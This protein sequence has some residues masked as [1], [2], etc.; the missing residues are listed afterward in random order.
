MLNLV[1]FRVQ[2]CHEIKNPQTF[3]P[4][5]SRHFEVFG[6]EIRYEFHVP[7]EDFMKIASPENYQLYG[8]IVL[9]RNT[10]ALI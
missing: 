3:Q 7:F 2:F 8:S 1:I 9:T 5:V 4:R 6:H 10:K